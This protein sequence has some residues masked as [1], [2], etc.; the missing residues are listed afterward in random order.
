MCFY[1]E[2]GE[3]EKEVNQ[4]KRL[5]LSGLVV[6]SLFGVSAHADTPVNAHRYELRGV[7]PDPWPGVVVFKHCGNAAEDSMSHLRM[8]VYIPGEKIVYRCKRYGY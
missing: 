4:M 2:N 5:L 3:N 6:A 8:M 7:D 1:R